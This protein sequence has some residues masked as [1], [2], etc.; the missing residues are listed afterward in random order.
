MRVLLGTTRSSAIFRNA[1]TF[2]GSHIID[3]RF[4]DSSARSA[5]VNCARYVC[6]FGSQL[7]LPETLCQDGCMR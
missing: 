4:F 2:A 3:G 7:V 1:S 5:F 6:Q